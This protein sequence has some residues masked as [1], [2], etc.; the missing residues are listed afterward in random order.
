MDGDATAE[1][2][3]AAASFPDKS[4]RSEYSEEDA[5]GDP[6]ATIP[7]PEKVRVIPP[8]PANRLSSS[9]RRAAVGLVDA[10][11]PSTFADRRPGRSVRRRRRR[12]S[13]SAGT[14]GLGST[15]KGG[16]PIADRSTLTR[17]TSFEVQGPRYASSHR[18]R[19]HLGFIR[20]RF[21]PYLGLPLGFTCTLPCF[22]AR[23]YVF[24]AYFE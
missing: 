24:I 10:T 20:V 3:L 13:L 14:L 18:L 11:P 12:S 8:S 9:A 1:K 6:R 5:R 23:I 22:C 15:S 16:H 19:L 2:C 4:A 21:K 17:S 7:P